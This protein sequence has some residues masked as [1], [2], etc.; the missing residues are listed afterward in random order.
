MWSFGVVVW[1]MFTLGMLPHYQLATDAAVISAVTSGMGTLER[2]AACPAAVYA[3]VM[4]PCWGQDA[5]NRPTFQSHIRAI[6]ETQESLLI[7]LAAQQTKF[8][9]FKF[10]PWTAPIIEWFK[11]HKSGDMVELVPACEADRVMAEARMRQTYPQ[12]RIVHVDEVLNYDLLRN[13]FAKYTDMASRKDHFLNGPNEMNLFH[14]TR[15]VDPMTVCRASFDPRHS[16]IGAIGRGIYLA[17]NANYSCSGYQFKCRD[18]TSKVFLASALI[19][20][21]MLVATPTPLRPT[22]DSFLHTGYANYVLS[23]P[24]QVYPRFLLTYT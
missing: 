24:S 22:F 15:T 2:P 17:T 1:E 4:L 11:T 3:Q 20:N 21:P 13:Y 10:P 16:N 6:R 23:E 12:A 7:E 19:G 18:G 8:D 9:M 14:G 5:A